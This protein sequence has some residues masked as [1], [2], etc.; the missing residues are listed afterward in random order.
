[1]HNMGGNCIVRLGALSGYEFSLNT[2]GPF[3]T[4]NVLILLLAPMYVLDERV[5][6]NYI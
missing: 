5:L 4:S 1:M 6:T 3:K 2:L